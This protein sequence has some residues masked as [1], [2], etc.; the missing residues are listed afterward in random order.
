M[1]GGEELTA[2]AAEET[3]V[4]EGAWAVELTKHDLSGK[5]TRILDQF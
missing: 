5:A 1:R 3:E 4:W 2:E